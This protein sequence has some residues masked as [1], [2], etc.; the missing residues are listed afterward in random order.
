MNRSKI[1]Y[2]PYTDKDYPAVKQLLSRDLFA[3]E[4]IV[5][6]LETAPELFVTAS[7]EERLVALAQVNEPV[8]Q[9][10]MTVYVDPQFRGQGIGSALAEYGE[11]KLREGG[12]RYIRSSFRVGH[13][14]SLAFARRLGFDK[15]FSS[16]YMQRT[17]D[18]FPPEEL[19]VRVYRDEDYIVSQEVYAVAFHEMRVRV[20]HFPDSVVAKPSEKERSE[21]KKEAEDRYVYEINGEIVAYSHLWENEISSIS[22]R[23]DFQRRGIGRKFVKF[24][25]NEIY[26]RGNPT[27]S[28]WCVVGNFARDLYDSLGFEEKYVMQFVRKTL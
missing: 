18:P 1:R 27:V 6:V 15:T 3:G 5:R 4:D 26:R 16:A 9:S 24:L 2:A 23:S 22:V 20:G 28:L 19:P 13:P 17:G 12:T 7:M 21:W 14:S 11:N 10:Y 25:C 8:I